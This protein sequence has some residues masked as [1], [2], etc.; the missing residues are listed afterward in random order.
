M[1]RRESELT[2]QIG[3]LTAAAGGFLCGFLTAARANGLFTMAAFI[4]TWT[5]VLLIAAAIHHG[6]TR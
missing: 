1:S 6:E 2:A 4:L 3:S 5:G